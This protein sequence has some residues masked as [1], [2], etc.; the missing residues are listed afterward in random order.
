MSS[1]V[2]KCLHMTVVQRVRKAGFRA[3]F[4]AV[5]VVTGVQSRDAFSGVFYTYLAMAG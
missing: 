1:F 2:G 3:I 5:T 4:A